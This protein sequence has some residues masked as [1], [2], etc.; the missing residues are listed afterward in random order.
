MFDAK[1]KLEVIGWIFLTV[2][3]VSNEFRKWW[4]RRKKKKT[5]IDFDVD[6]HF[7]IDSILYQMLM[8]YDACRATVI[9]FHNGDEYYTGQSRIRMTITNE[10]V[11][12][13]VKKISQDYS[14]V[15]VSQIMHILMR[16]IRVTDYMYIPLRETGENKVAGLSDVM[17]DLD[18]KS[19]ILIRLQD[20]KTGET[21]AIL[22]LHFPHA[23]A[24]NREHITTLMRSKNRLETIFDRL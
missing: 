20:S 17:V 23:N 6:I 22:D 4:L 12:P 24:L 16:D 10:V 19:F 18:M 15:Q 9:Q 1:E 13:G 11:F 2:V 8:L 5:A 3:Y 14:G 21:V 7:K